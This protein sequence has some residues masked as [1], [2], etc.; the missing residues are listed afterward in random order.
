METRPVRNTAAAAEKEGTA[1]QWTYEEAFVRNRGLVSPDEQQRLRQSCVAIPG[2]GGVGGVHLLTLTRLGIGA[3]RI[4]DPD[5]FEVANFNRQSGADT[6]TVGRGKA[7]VMAEKALAINPQLDLNVL[8]EPINREN[9]AQFLDG[10]DVMVDGIDYFSFDTRRLLFCEARR[11]GIWAITAG[12]VGFSTPWIVFDPAGMSFDDYFD[13]HDGMDPLDQMAA[14]T[15]GLTPRAT[16]WGYFDLSQVD[17]GSGRGPSLGLACNLAGGVAAS[18]VAK[19][20]LGRKP[21]RPA[22]YF[23]QFDAYR[24]ILRCGRLRWGNRHPWQRIKRRILKQRL[25]KIGLPQFHVTASEETHGLAGGE[26]G[27]GQT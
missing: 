23:A 21:L 11:R 13:L 14:F 2:M 17:Q 7:G 3:F 16:H 1:S 5:H 9:V 26:G 24:G 10:V 19:I 15:I 4:A 20:I 22:P 8:S 18:E 25:R 6:E 12:P 27:A